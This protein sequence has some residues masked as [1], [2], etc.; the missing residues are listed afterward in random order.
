MQI[1]DTRKRRSS[2]KSG[3]TLIEIILVIGLLA[4]L[5]GLVIGNVDKIFGNQQVEMAR[6]KVNESF[7]TPLTTSSTRMERPPK[8][9]LSGAQ[10]TLPRRRLRLSTSCAAMP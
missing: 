7:K 10:L 3:F 2:R 9:R 1:T 4:I 8:T 6:F 5:A